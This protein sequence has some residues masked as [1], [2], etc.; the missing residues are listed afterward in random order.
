MCAASR[1]PYEVMYFRS[2]S[3]GNPGSGMQ[4]ISP[5]QSKENFENISSLFLEFAQGQSDPGEE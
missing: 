1:L 2:F 5:G 4:I 3:R